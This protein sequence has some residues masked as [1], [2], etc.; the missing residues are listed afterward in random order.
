GSGVR[1]VGV[2]TCPASVMLDGE[3]TKPCLCE[4]G[5]TCRLPSVVEQPRAVRRRGSEH[6]G[7]SE[8]RMVQVDVDRIK[9]QV[10]AA[11]AAR[12]GEPVLR[13][14]VG[15]EGFSN[16]HGAA[17][18]KGRL[19]RTGLVLQAL[20]RAGGRERPPL[21]LKPSPEAAQA[22]ARRVAQAAKVRRG[23]VQG[24]KAAT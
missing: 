22:H 13:G 18:R 3:R 2:N 19:E 8:E 21:P 11:K 6:A 20:E 12:P 5:E 10:A 24:M 7:G 17:L 1:G 9:A 16:E 15:W 14:R 4:T 23:L